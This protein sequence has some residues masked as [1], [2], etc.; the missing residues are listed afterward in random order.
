MELI[1][2]TGLLYFNILHWTILV[3]VIPIFLI[4]M[5][6]N[7]RCANRQKKFIKEIEI[8]NT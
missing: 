8:S 7:F 1:L 3:L 4:D 2:L 6:S 5:L